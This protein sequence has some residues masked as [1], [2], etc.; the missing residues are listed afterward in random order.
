M[1]A[2]NF[3]IIIQNSGAAGNKSIIKVIAPTFFQKSAFKTE[4]II[5][6]STKF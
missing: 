2:Y 1:F 5:L 3:E 4:K 6:F